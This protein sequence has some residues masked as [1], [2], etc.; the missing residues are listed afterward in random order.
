MAVT[1]DLL[2]AWRSPGRSIRRHLNRGISEPFAFSLLMV[3]V[4]LALVGHWP[5]A[6]REAFLAEEPSA[7]PRMLAFALALLA[8]IPLFYGLAAV[9]R[10]VARALGGQGTWYG[11]R[12]SLFWALAV[13]GPLMLLLGLVEAM[14]GPGAQ[15]NATRGVVGLAF[16]GFWILMMREESRG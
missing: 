10:L 9:A 6:A 13:T 7:M 8:T 4:L 2:A 5:V 1:T 14:I 12:L 16:L 3:F 15:L 11:A